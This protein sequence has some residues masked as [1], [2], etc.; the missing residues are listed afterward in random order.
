MIAT[1]G[2][3]WIT[4]TSTAVTIERDPTDDG[5]YY[6]RAAAYDRIGLDNLSSSTAT[7]SIE[8]L[9]R[10]CYRAWPMLSTER[11]SN[12]SPLLS[13]RRPSQLVRC[14]P[15]PPRSSS[16]GCPVDNGRPGRLLRGPRA[17]GSGPYTV[18]ALVDDP[19][20]PD[21]PTESAFR[22]AGTDYPAEVVALYTAEVPGMF[23]PNLRALRDEVIRTAD[24]RAPYDL[25]QRLVEVLHSDTYRY[26]TD[27]RDVECGTMSTPE[28]FATSKRGYCQHYAT[29]MAVVLRNLGVPAR[30]V[31]GF[32]PGERP[33]GSSVPGDQHQ[34]RPCVGRGVPPGP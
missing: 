30:V 32:L 17:R 29:T 16:I 22:A 26:D 10:P 3:Q 33:V 7:R 13:G 11:G 19:D 9:A 4:D 2:G 23:G 34:S 28:C 8:P 24:S 20:S 31:S 15:L 12:R 5:R 21:V 25:A 18:T 1:I 6:W 14:C 27:V